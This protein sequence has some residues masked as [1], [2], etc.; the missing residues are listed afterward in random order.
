MR[1]NMEEEQFVDELILLD[2]ATRANAKEDRKILGKPSFFKRLLSGLIDILSILLIA[3]GLFFIF[4]LTVMKADNNYF[5]KVD[6]IDTL[7]QE[8][9]LY[10]K[11]GSKYMTLDYDP[12]VADDSIT[13]YYTNCY[14]PKSL[15]ALEEYNKAK[16][17]SKLFTLENEKYILK[18]DVDGDSVKEFFSF[19]Y[20]EALNVFDSNPELIKLKK[21][22][23]LMMIWT[24]SGTLMISSAIFYLLIPLL[25]KDGESIGEM[26]TKLCIIDARDN[27]TVKRWQLVMRYLVILLFDILVGTFLTY[28]WELSALFPGILSIAVMGLNKENRSIHCFA[29]QTVVMDKSAKR[30]IDAHVK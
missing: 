23:K 14:Y 3:T 19:Y 15:N 21:E 13:Y 10:R 18:G 8:S 28:L 11:D 30:K 6:D 20:N 16:E 2:K 4:Q 9:H 7:Y 26:I 29:S 24:V 27:S 17:A 22:T 25:R 1:N 5:D 12:I